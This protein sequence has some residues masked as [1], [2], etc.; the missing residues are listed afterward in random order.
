MVEGVD[1]PVSVISI[2]HLPSLLPR[3]ASDTFSQDLLP[4]LLTLN[5]WKNDPVWAGAD[6]L[7]KEKVATLPQ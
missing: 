3:E 2:D 5:D 1:P 6:K 7:Y 4:Y